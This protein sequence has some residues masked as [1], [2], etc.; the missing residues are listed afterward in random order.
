[1]MYECTKSEFHYYPFLLQVAFEQY[2]SGPTIQTI[3]NFTVTNKNYPKQARSSGAPAI[4]IPIP[5][6]FFD[7]EPNPI[8]VME[9]SAVNVVSDNSFTVKTMNKTKPTPTRVLNKYSCLTNDNDD[10]DDDDKLVGRTIATNRRST[11]G[12]PIKSVSNEMTTNKGIDE[13]DDDDDDDDDGADATPVTLETCELQN[14]KIKRN[15]PTKAVLD[16]GTMVSNNKNMPELDKFDDDAS[17]VTVAT[18]NLSERKYNVPIDIPYGFFD[19]AVNQ[20]MNIPKKPKKPHK[21]KRKRK[22]KHG[23]QAMDSAE[24]NNGKKRDHD[25]NQSNENTNSNSGNAGNNNSNDQG[26][27]DEM[28]K[29]FNQFN[30]E[31]CPGKLGSADDATDVEKL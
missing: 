18:E 25:G 6:N 2:F 17:A 13:R 4:E 29:D 12:L 8:P 27:R 11:T 28:N 5:P 21:K 22:K 15:L 26:E 30:D 10:D 14:T 31:Q 23:K 9:T 24:G 19:T 3:L 1:M 16:L 7:I 20:A